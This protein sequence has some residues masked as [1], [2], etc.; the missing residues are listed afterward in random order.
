MMKLK[1]QGVLFCKQWREE[2]HVKLT[3]AL[4]FEN[5]EIKKILFGY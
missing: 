3:F 5:F 4:N 1:L 2:K